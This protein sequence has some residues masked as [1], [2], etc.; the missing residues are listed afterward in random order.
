[1]KILITGG[2]GYKGTVLTKKL[3]DAGYDV[4]AMDNFMYGSADT[5]PGKSSTTND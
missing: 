1:M 3:L 4:T 5:A 2:A